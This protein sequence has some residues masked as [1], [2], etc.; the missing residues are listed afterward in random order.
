MEQPQGSNPLEIDITHTIE[1]ST[2]TRTTEGDITSSCIVAVSSPGDKS[3][4]A[5]PSGLH[6]D[7]YTL[8]RLSEVE[9]EDEDEKV[10]EIFDTKIG[11]TLEVPNIEELGDGSWEMVV[12]KS[13]CRALQDMLGKI[14]PGSNVDLNYDPVEP[15]ASDL[16]FLGYDNAKKLREHLFSQ[17]AER[18]I[19]WS[20]STV[21]AYYA[22]RLG[23]MD[24]LREG[25]AGSSC[26]KSS[27]Q[28]LVPTYRGYLQSKG[29]AVYLL[30]ACFGG[31]LVH[32]CRGPRD[33]EVTISGNVFVWEANSTGIDS[34]RDG[35]EWTVWEQDGFEVGEAI[36]G[37]GLM[38]KTI[39]IPACRAIHH[40]VSY[41]TAGDARTL[42]RP[43]RSMKL[44][45]ELASILQVRGPFRF[46]SSAQTSGMLVEADSCDDQ[47]QPAQFFNLV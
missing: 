23:V 12:L 6:V 47:L 30:Q 2:A 5:P 25:A 15:A 10:W 28:P 46:I 40:V 14:Y 27:H 19:N 21:A 39:S 24:G 43:S 1:V 16:E 29:D 37:S 4:P 31:R 36:D 45:P 9:V 20:W 22:Y 3:H 38:K 41:Y 42:A 11:T 44:S 8:V 34:W 17:R 26:L 7:Q 35:M 32:S 18:I 13:H 33:G